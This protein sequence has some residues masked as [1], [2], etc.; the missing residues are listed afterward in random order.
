MYYILLF[1]IALPL[2]L[3]FFIDW[4]I[5]TFHMPQLA[6]TL[7]ILAA[8]TQFLCTLIP[9]TGG[10]KSYIHRILASLSAISLL[11]VVAIIVANSGDTTA[12]T[13]SAICF[14]S[15]VGVVAVGAVRALSTKKIE[16]DYVLIFQSSYYLAF[17]VAVLSATYF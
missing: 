14:V 8:V 1:S 17:F 4:F 13:I 7:L 12:E 16:H 10:V 3:L 15:M 2:L 9:E 11:P 5:P 6:T